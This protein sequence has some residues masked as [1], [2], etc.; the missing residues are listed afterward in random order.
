MIAA[1]CNK[2]T[3]TDG[4]KPPRPTSS[5][6]SGGGPS[7]DTKPSPPLEVTADQLSDAFLAD[8]NAAKAKYEDKWLIVDGLYEKAY[9]RYFDN[10]EVLGRML[11]FTEYKD[12]KKRGTCMIGCKVG[13]DQWPKVEGLSKGQKIKI[14]AHY[15]SGSK[16][17]VDLKDCELLAAGPDPAIVVS[18]VQLTKDYAADKETARRKYPDEKPLLVEGVV[19][20]TR[21]MDEPI[22]ILEGFDEKAAKPVRVEA[23]FDKIDR[24]GLSPET[25]KKGDKVKIKG[26]SGWFQSEDSV[27][28]DQCKVLR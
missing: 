24:A 19:F 3:T 26:R 23:H 16:Q 8:E 9:T 21:A 22:I 4:G 20:E 18:A 2:P 10:G 7:A 14:K 13:A 1:G 25:V 27:Y 6:A 17:S 28:L 5:P 11:W 12:P 15:Y